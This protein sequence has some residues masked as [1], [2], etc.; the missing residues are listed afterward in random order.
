MSFTAPNHARGLTWSLSCT[1][2]YIASVTWYCV[3]TQHPVDPVSLATGGVSIG[4]LIYGATIVHRALLANIFPLGF[5][6]YSGVWGMSGSLATLL[7]IAGLLVLLLSSVVILWT[8]YHSHRD[9]LTLEKGLP[10]AFLL[11]LPLVVHQLAGHLLGIDI[12]DAV[13]SGLLGL[14]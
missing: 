12:Y 10:V 4:L 9:K 6:F 13:F 1:W 8:V 3:L 2:L 14:P 11:A 5:S 7:Q